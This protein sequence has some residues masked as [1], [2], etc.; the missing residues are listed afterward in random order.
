[1]TPVVG[2]YFPGKLF[3]SHQI[4]NTVYVSVFPMQVETKTGKV[5]SLVQGNW[6]LRLEKARETRP[7]ISHKPALIVTSEKLLEGAKE[8][9]QFH[10]SSL[11]VESEIVT[12]ETISQKAD[13]IDEKELP[14]GF[15]NPEDFDG[16]VKGYGF[17]KAK[18]IISFLRKR[19]SEDSQFKYVVLL[20]NSELVPPS[21]YFSDKTSFG[22]KTTGV[23]D[24]C[25]GAGKL[26]LEP[27]LAVGRLP[28]DSN[29]QVAAYLEKARKWHKNQ[30]KAEN[31]LALYGGK[32]FKSSRLYIGELGTLVTLNQESADWKGTLKHFQTEGN[33]SKA[34]IKK[35]VT[36]DE[37]ASLV[38]YLDHGMGNRWY[39]GDDFVSSK[40]ILDTVPRED[41]L[42][43]VVVSVACINAAFDEALLIDDTLS[44]KDQWGT[45]SVGTALLKSK[46]GAIAYLGGA[47]DGLGSPETEID[48]NG[49]VEVL[50]TTHGLQFFDGFVENYR[51]SDGKRMGDVLV[52]SLQE[53]SQTK[54]NNMDEFS[55]RWTY[56][57]SELLGDPLLP[58][59]RQ[60]KGQP[61]YKIAKSDFQHFDNSTGFP[62]L[63]LE[64]KK[65]LPREFPIS[66]EAGAVT[67]KVFEILASDEGFSGEK[68]IK[69]VNLTESLSD[70]IPIELD[71]DV[72][73]G[74]Q[75]MIKLENKEGIP[76]ER[77]I[78]FSTTEAKN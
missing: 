35:L 64:P 11:K 19:A 12:V 65:E 1:Q 72:A 7:V 71:S 61:G 66:K 34:D 23:T 3:E 40:D 26:C 54:G 45:V 52:E 17:L 49:N 13:P 53:Y 75:Y 76:R 31:E 78:V 60:S 8:L 6:A 46:A 42:P 62:R 73:P 16:N 24:Q 77:H 43:P 25:Y 59:K 74:K 58:V 50:G 15:K 9:Q 41:S 47:R 67:A 33:F 39:A 18:K 68:L 22:E 37:K 14:E 28:F 27:R 48:E 55:H 5:L 56:W 36:G 32:A 10:K 70:S 44:E 30:E 29:E 21:Y 51:E 63:L 20:G 69:T 4:G 2:E 57:I 38:Y